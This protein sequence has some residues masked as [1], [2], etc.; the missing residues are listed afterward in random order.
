MK[1]WWLNATLRERQVVTLGAILVGLFILY[2]ITLV[3]LSNKVDSMRKQIQNNQTLLAWMQESDKRIKQLSSN[4]K[5]SS[6]KSTASL[7]NLLQTDID[8]TS[9][10]KNV[11]LLQQADNDSV[12]IHLQKAGFDN[13]MKWLINISQE[14]QLIILQASFVPEPTPG[15]VEADL[16]IQ[17]T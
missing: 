10:A 8:K 6:P 16:K 5:N 12:Q 15:I 13:L 1:S 3:P 14:Q 7:L 9:L 11:S 4:P 2:E 17:A